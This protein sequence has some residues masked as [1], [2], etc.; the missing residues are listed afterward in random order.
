MNRAGGGVGAQQH[1]KALNLTPAAEIDRVAQIAR[2]I[3]TQRRLHP[4]IIA[5]MGQQII[6]TVE[7]CAIGNVAFLS[8]NNSFALIA[9]HAIKTR[10][11]WRNRAI[12]G[13]IAMNG[14]L[15]KCPC[16]TAV[17][18]RDGR[19]ALA[20]H[21]AGWHGARMAGRRSSGGL[22]GGV[23]IAIGALV[24]AFAGAS[25]GQPSAGLVIGV[26]LGVLL[27]ALIWLVQRKRG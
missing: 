5:E 22:G 12:A 6:G 17:P 2:A 24:G 27:A 21:G 9:H 13:P 7:G 23:L 8:Q 16:G 14:P 1:H 15:T 25:Q 4:G 11:I 18:A 20:Q 3:G 10:A 19:F 26:A